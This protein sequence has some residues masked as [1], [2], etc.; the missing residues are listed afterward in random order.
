V[1]AAA[2]FVTGAILMA[3]DWWPGAG[4]TGEDD[5]D[6]IALGHARYAAHCAS[7][8][9][10]ALEGQP[11]WRE[12][13]PSGELPAPPHDETGHTW[14]HP[15]EQL[16]R[17]TKEGVA[18]FAPEG[19]VTDMPGFAEAL[20]DDEIRAVLAYIKSTWPAEIRAHQES[21]TRQSQ[22]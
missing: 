14:H 3:V 7:C 13:L 8:H 21:T 2:I 12:R 5:A 20:T 9:G 18:P 15:D 22:Q 10:A 11:N 16:F 6:R 19:Y 4:P 17:L 1:A